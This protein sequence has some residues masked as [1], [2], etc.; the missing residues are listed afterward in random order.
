ML[1][2]LLCLG[3]NVNV[4]VVVPA[5]GLALL[6]VEDLG[7]LLGELDEPVLELLDTLLVALGVDHAQHLVVLL[8]D[9]ELEG[10][11]VVGEEGV[12][13]IRQISQCSALFN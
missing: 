3:L 1:L 9:V 10:V 5:D 6:A 12:V 2:P 8:V 4:L 11:L 13:S 7:L